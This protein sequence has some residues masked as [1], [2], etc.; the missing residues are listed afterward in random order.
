MSNGSN[1]DGRTQVWFDHIEVHVQEVI[2][3][4]DFQQRLFRGGRRRPITDDGIHMFIAPDGIR[5]E[6]EPLAPAAAWG[7]AGLCLPGTP[8]LSTE[9]GSSGAGGNCALGEGGTAGSGGDGGFTTPGETDGAGG[10]GGLLSG[11]G[12]GN[13]NDGGQGGERFSEG[14][15]GFRSSGGLGNGGFDGGGGGPDDSADD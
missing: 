7:R 12:N 5:I 4:G 9:A 1:S 8:R 13:A 6:V 14:T 15:G 10:G 11:G 3:Y 2:A